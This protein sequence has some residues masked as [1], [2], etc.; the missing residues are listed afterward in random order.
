MP[1]AVWP[2]NRNPTMTLLY[3]D[4][5]FLRHETGQHPERPDRLRS[6]TARLDQT[7]L[8]KKCTAGTYKP[9]TEDEVAKLH[10]PAVVHRVKQVAAH[11]GGR[12]DADTVV[13]KDS[14]DVGLA[15]AGACCAAVDAVLKG[16][17]RNALCLVRP[18]GHHA[19]PTRSMGFCL[20]NNVALAARRARTVHGVSRI[21]IVDWDVHH[22]NGTQDVFYDDDTVLFF[23][24]HRFGMG[25]YPGTGAEDETGEGKGL[26]YTVNVPVRYGTSRKD[27]RA[28]FTAAL[29]KAADK[30]KPELVLLSA[31]FDAHA[32][33]PIGSLGLESED[34]VALSGDVLNVAKA[35]ARGRLVSCLEGGYNLDALAESVQA[36]LEQLLADKP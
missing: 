21:L 28:R 8:V 15:A 9:L 4:P 16:M 14:F 27:Y 20:F 31:G 19:T 6:V 18:P 30:M 35:H 7:G 23:S 12:L 32:Q 25:F 2:R 26:G 17:D 1:P 10:A 13:S 5:L 11:G 3:T 33:D 24:I 36:H 34:F 29:E 22:G